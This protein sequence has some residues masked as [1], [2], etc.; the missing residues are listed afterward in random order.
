MLEQLPLT[1]IASILGIVLIVIFLITS[2]DTAT[3]IMASMTDKG[4]MNPHNRLKVI[5][6]VLIAA[7]ASVLLFSGGLEALQTASLISAL[8]FTVVMLLLIVSFFK[9][10]K[11]EVIPIT[12]RDV[13]RHKRIMEHIEKTENN[14]N[15]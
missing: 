6:G 12:K 8:P 15:K 4:T 7:I 11:H 14:T 5:W 13:R 2:G 10:I 1:T 9:M 3:F